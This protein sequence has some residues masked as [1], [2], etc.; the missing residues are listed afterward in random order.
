MV[1]MLDLTEKSCRSEV[2]AQLRD[3]N[4]V[5]TQNISHPRG[6]LPFGALERALLGLPNITAEDKEPNNFILAVHYPSAVFFFSS[7]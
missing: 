1:T 4:W 5:L 6:C 2:G 3:S 7:C